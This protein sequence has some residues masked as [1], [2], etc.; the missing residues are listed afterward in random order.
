VA[1]LPITGVDTRADAILTDPDHVRGR[2]ALR[3]LDDVELDAIALGEALEAAALDGRVVH[4]AVLAPVLGG[5]E[6]EALGV[7]ES[8]HFTR[9]AHA[10]FSF[11][12]V[13]ARKGWWSEPVPF[14]EML[15]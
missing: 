5:D 6:P 15:V 1:F 10:F 12:V 4:E 11:L 14:R 7:I 2:G 9:V 3:S 13:A 8:L